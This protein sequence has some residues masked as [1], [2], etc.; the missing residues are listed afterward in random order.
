MPIPN[1]AHPTAIPAIARVLSVD[2][3]RLDEEG[4]GDVEIG[5][6]VLYI[7]VIEPDTLATV[8]VTKGD[9]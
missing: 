1:S 5:V 4:G 7:V 2:L 8:L 9:G 3:A 6:R